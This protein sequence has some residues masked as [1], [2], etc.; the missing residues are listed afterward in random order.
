MILCRGGTEKAQMGRKGDRLDTENY[1]E[2]IFC[3]EAV[4]VPAQAHAE[5]FSNQNMNNLNHMIM[6][7]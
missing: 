3:V 4:S 1:V 6:N 2:S 7:Q 5:I